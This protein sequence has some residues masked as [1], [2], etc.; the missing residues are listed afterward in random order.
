MYIAS[1]RG[2]ADRTPEPGCTNP[3]VLAA[4]LMMR[5]SSG[6]FGQEARR[7]NQPLAFHQV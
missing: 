3:V 1:F 4:L 5:S 2:S 7:L 6:S